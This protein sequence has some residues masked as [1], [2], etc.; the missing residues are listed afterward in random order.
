MDNSILDS[1]KKLLG[2]SLED[3]T[4]DMDVIIHI[5]TVFSIL[6]QLGVGPDGGFS[7]SDNTTTWDEYINDNKLLNDVITYVYLKTQLIFDP[8]TTS[9]VTEAKNKMISELEFRMNVTVDDQKG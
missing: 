3:D 5:N 8:P 1:I 6:N 9:S 4:F 2:I 7:I